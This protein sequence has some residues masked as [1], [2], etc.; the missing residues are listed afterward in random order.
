MFTTDTPAAPNLVL[1]RH[2]ATLRHHD[3]GDSAALIAFGLI[4]I[5]SAAI[6]FIGRDYF[7]DIGS[8][9]GAGTYICMSVIACA[10]MVVREARAIGA[11][12]PSD[13]APGGERTFHGAHRPRPR[14]VPV[15]GPGYGADRG[16]NMRTAADA[17]APKHA[18]DSTTAA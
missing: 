1:G 17:V 14:P 6:T 10:V 2:A 5:S 4:I 16:L 7:G 11:S 18:A 15:P 8:Y 9:V 12:N 3:P 13:T